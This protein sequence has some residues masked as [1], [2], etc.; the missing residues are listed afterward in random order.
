MADHLRKRSQEPAGMEQEIV[1]CLQV[2]V[3]G[4]QSD[5]VVLKSDHGVIKC[6]KGPDFGDSQR[7][8]VGELRTEK[9]ELSAAN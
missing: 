8:M 5:L 1:H 2:S 4:W 6:F 3:H 9:R 7:I